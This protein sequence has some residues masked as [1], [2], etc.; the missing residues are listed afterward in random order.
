[1]SPVEGDLFHWNATI[2]PKDSLWEGIN[3]KVSVNHVRWYRP[4]VFFNCIHVDSAF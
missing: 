3:T 4:H 2:R 1:M